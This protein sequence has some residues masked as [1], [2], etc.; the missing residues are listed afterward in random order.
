M[1][2]P[3][4]YVRANPA[5]VETSIERQRTLIEQMLKTSA[6]YEV[7]RQDAGLREVID[8]IES[9]AVTPEVLF[10][11]DVAQLTRMNVLEA[12]GLF[13]VLREH[14]IEMYVVDHGNIDVK[15]DPQTI[16]DLLSE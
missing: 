9:G 3:T 7:E 4:T 15:T 6:R 16:I 13:T 14:G 5:N 12:A 2:A 10:V 11:S 8:D 1:K